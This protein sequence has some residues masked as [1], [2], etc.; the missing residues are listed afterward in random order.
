VN[1]APPGCRITVSYP[2]RACSGQGAPCVLSQ[3][4]AGGCRRPPISVP[5]AGWDHEFESAFLRQRV[6]KLSIP[7]VTQSAAN[8]MSGGIGTG[9]PAGSSQGRRP[10]C[11]DLLRA[12]IGI[13]PADHFPTADPIRGGL[14][15]C[16]VIARKSHHAHAAHRSQPGL[17]NAADMTAPVRPSAFAI[18]RMR[19]LR[20]KDAC[21]DRDRYLV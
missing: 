14:Y 11:R 17:I 3:D 1:G 6:C 2:I 15:L 21:F 13:V 4:N 16:D 9:G 19:N 5:F 7:A 18:G 10:P 12:P 8:P 20:V